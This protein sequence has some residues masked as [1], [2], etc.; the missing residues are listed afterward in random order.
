MTS[1]YVW[2]KY[3]LVLAG[4]LFLL[5]HG[6]AVFAA[7][8]LKKES[9]P[10][11]I[12]AMLDLSASSWPPMMLSLLVLLVAGI[13]TG[14]MGN[15]WGTVWIWLSLVILLG[16]TFWMFSLGQRAYH[17]LRK[18]VGQPYLI[19]GKPFPAEKPRPIAEIKAHLARTRPMEVLVVGIGGFAFI[20]W[21]MIFK[22]F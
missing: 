2:L 18:M 1:L 7:F 14:F 20:L 16:I 9:D 15:W 3:I 12:K 17:P 5:S 19:K 10:E 11:R 8:Q 21:L 22:P 13:I 6:T 4:F